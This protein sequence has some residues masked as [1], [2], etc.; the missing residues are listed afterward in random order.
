VI[1]L[2]P[3]LAKNTGS[4]VQVDKSHDM[5]LNAL[6]LWWHN[7]V[8]GVGV[9]VRVRVTARAEALALG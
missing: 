9:R 1:C 2:E 5:P 8:V 6:D 7:G 3:V 4:P